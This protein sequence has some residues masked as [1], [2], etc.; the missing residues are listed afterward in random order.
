MSELVSLPDNCG[1]NPGWSE[2][3]WSTDTAAPGLLS[4]YFTMETDFFPFV[5]HCLLLAVLNMHDAQRGA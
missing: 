5:H 1:N 3:S 2:W 4:V